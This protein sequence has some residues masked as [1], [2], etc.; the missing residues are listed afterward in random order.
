MPKAQNLVLTQSQAACLIALRHGNETQPKIALEAKLIL[1]KTAA[2][3]R[4]LVGLGLAEQD[5]TRRWHPTGRG[6]ACRFETVPDRPRQ[7]NSLPGL[8]GQRLLDL[9]DR[10][11]QGREIVKKLGMTHQ[12]VRQ[13]LIKLHAQG[14]VRFADP[15]IPFWIVARADDKTSLLSRDE[16]RVLSATKIRLASGVSENK[17]HQILERLLVRRL[18][19]VSDGPWEQRIYRITSAGLK[20]PQCS[21][22]G[23]RAQALRLPVESDRI[24][25]VLSV[26]LDSGELRI[27]DVT[28]VL[29]LP[30]QSMNALMQYLKRR[31]LVKKSNPAHNSPYLLTAEGLAALAEMTRR[32]AA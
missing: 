19:E 21:Q 20:H 14:H 5:P 29:S 26:I 11:K 12:G 17:V 18:I 3:L 28:N 15:E 6:T 30:P 2:A 16:E 24:R 9:L 27:K 32:Q 31:R 8:A 25:N 22:S 1:S 13:L 4:T 23:R 10:P 7:N